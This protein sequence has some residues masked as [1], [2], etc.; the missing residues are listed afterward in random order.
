MDKKKNI[1]ISTAKIGYVGNKASFFFFYKKL[2][3]TQNPNY[4]FIKLVRL[5][6]I[7]IFF[8]F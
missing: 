7:F 2:F 5:T 1:S 4:E 8:T 3:R 6:W